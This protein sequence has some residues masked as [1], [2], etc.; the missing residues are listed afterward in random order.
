MEPT[1]P[2]TTLTVRQAYET[3]YLSESLELKPLTRERYHYEIQRWERFSG[4]P[5][6]REIT[7]ETAN[8]FRRTLLEAGYATDSIESTLTIVHGVLK[9]AAEAE[10][11]PLEA[12]PPRG[13][14]LK[15]SD[16]KPR[17][18]SVSQLGD[19]YRQAQV[20]TW[21]RPLIAADGRCLTTAMWWQCYDVL[22]LFTGCRLSDLL[23]SLHWSGVTEHALSFTARKTGRHHVI[24]MH[25]VLRRH[26]D[27]LR[28]FDPQQ[29]LPVKRCGQLIRRE[30]RRRCAA[31]CVIPAVTPK[32]LRQ[33][34]GTHWELAE[35]GAGPKMLGHSLGVSDR[36]ISIPSV[37]KMAVK[38]LVL[39]AGW[40]DGP[41]PDGPDCRD[42]GDFDGGPDVIPFPR[43]A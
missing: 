34:A 2:P 13:R 11:C 5:D 15:L 4:D 42:T 43:S 19:L 16:P 27:A 26:L 20:C 32:Q 21:P 9:V 3:W 28:G 30:L 40:H 10:S 22:M 1:L 31:A 36:Y 38:R 8:T 41:G 18:L 14:R 25:P 33:N 7:R 6:I 24:P 35:A 23:H 37:L 39:P 12:C 17:A 29:I